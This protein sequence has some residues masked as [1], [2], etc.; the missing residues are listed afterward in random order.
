MMLGLCAASAS[1]Q[2]LDLL[3]VYST[4][5]GETLKA[6][7]DAGEKEVE[8]VKTVSFNMQNGGK[9]EELQSYDI[10]EGK[11][12]TA[13]VVSAP[14]VEYA[15]RMVVNFTD[16]T[17]IVSD[18]V[19]VSGETFKWLGDL[20]W[21]S[22]SSGYLSPVVDRGIENNNVIVNGQTYYKQV[23]NHA[24]G[25]LEYKLDSPYTRFVSR[26]GTID[27][28]SYGDLRFKFLADGVVKHEQ[29]VFAK[30]NPSIGS[31]PCIYDVDMSL[32]GVQTL[33][34]NFEIYD[35]NNWGDHGHLLLARL[36]LPQEMDER[37]SQTV[38]FATQGGTVPPGVT[39]MELKATASSGLPVY[40]HVV[41]GDAEIVDGNRLVFLNNAFGEVVVEAVQ[42][43]DETYACAVGTLVLNVD[44]KPLITVLGNQVSTTGNDY[45]YVYVDAKNRSVSSVKMQLYSNPDQ[46][47]SAG[48]LDMANFASDPTFSEP[49]V[50]IIPRSMLLSECY[51]FTAEFSD[52]QEPASIS[53]GYFDGTA[54]IVYVSDTKYY[55][56]S[57]NYNNSVSTDISVG[58]ET[59]NLAGKVYPKGLGVHATGTAT[60]TLPQGVFNRFVTTVGKQNG[61]WGN[62]AY[63][64]K[65]NGEQIASTGSISASSPVKWDFPLASDV[66]ELTINIEEG[67]DGNG[68]DHGTMGGTRLYYTPKERK[69]QTIAWLDSK[70][71]LAYKPTDVKL[72]ARASSG[73]PVGYR[74]IEGNE[75]AEIRE[76]GILH[77]HTVPEGI[78]TLKVEAFQPGDKDWAIA[79]LKICTFT[80]SNGFVVERDETLKLNG[81]DVL[82][83]LT[84]YAD[85]YSSGQVLVEDGVV[86]VKNLILKYTFRPSEYTYVSFPSSMNLGQVSNFEELGF[87]Y[88]PEGLGKSY[89]IYE[90][91][92]R[93]HAADPT[94]FNWKALSE[95][96]VQGGKGYVFRLNGGLADDVE[97]T[98]TVDNANLEFENSIDLLNLTLD[99][100]TTEPG[101]RQAVYVRPKN[102]NG[103]TLRIDVDYKPSDLSALPINH[104]RAL[105]DARV[106]YVPGFAGIRLTLPDNTPAKLAIYDA[107]G[108]KLVKAVRYV[109]PMMID[110]RDLKAGNYQMIVSYGNAIGVKTFVKPNIK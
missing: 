52:G 102:V 14:G 23:G 1:A 38:A 27:A 89:T 29:V 47:V 18:C 17:N 5:G 2:T 67:G 32:E 73:L 44:L 90:Y 71:V 43:G 105:A 16:G 84:I 108:E 79:P 48:E 76:G 80:V 68:A 26:F 74:V 107:S 49:Q 53:T 55:K 37:E 12:V 15:Y 97:V 8:S 91:D 50:L 61:R 98:F 106:T 11:Y 87:A 72:T 57:S 88:S 99:F 39:S 85:A 63:V 103:N 59:L 51:T 58:G 30:T 13:D 86:T 28:N 36:Y 9:P 92:T 7:I 110:I 46:M 40:Y 42:F 41:K 64:L 62:I 21:S 75:W 77:I 82:D 22:Y 69:A 93:M 31:N 24:A 4:P 94:A 60:I 54:E 25:Y 109:S 70:P 20:K 35:G 78:T 45:L 33:R 101:I 81:G 65:R 83:E 34:F 3:G 104:E 10:F 100:G 95:P 19:E 66:Y 56:L 6:V 96:K